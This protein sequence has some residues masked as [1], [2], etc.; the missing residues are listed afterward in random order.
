MT[1]QV[2][3]FVLQGGLDMVS[4][5]LTIE[6][7][8]LWRG[9]N[10]EPVE[11]G[12]RRIAG[13]ERYSGKPSPSDASYWLLSRTLTGEDATVGQ[14]VTGGTSAATGKLLTIAGDD[15][16]LGEVSGMFDTGEELTGPGGAIGTVSGT[17][18]KRGA[19]MLSDDEDYLDLAAA[20]RRAAIVKVPGSGPVRGV[21]SYAGD[22]FAVRDN[23][24]GMAGVMYRATS[25]GWTAV[26]GASLPVGGVY[27]FINHNFMGQ[28]G[29]LTMY[30]VN[31]V[32]KAFS[33]IKG[34]TTET[35]TWTFASI[36]T[37]GSGGAARDKPTHIAVQ[38]NHLLFAYR[39]G[40]LVYSSTG[41]PT[42]Y[43]AASGAGEIACGQEV[44]GLLGGVGLGN[45]LIVGSD[46][47][48][49]LYGN[50][51]EDFVLQDQSQANTG[52]VEGTL[53]AVGG[54][55]Y[56]D[57]RGVRSV[58]TTEAWGNWVIGTMTAD[59]QPW[60]DFQREARNI[61]A[62]SMRVRSNDQ[63]RLFFESGLGLAIYVGRDRPEMSFIDYGIDNDVTL[64][65]DEGETEPTVGDILTG[66]TSEATAR[67]GRVATTSGSWAG[68]NAAGTLSLY[69]VRGVFENDELV[70][71]MSGQ[72]ARVNG[73]A[74]S[75]SNR[76]IPRVSVSTE[77][78][79]RIERVYFGADNG[80]VY[81]AERGR[82]FDGREYD[83]Y[84]RMPLNH[85]KQPSRQKRFLSADIHLDSSGRVNLGL[86]ALYEDGINPEQPNTYADV[87]S[88]G[89]FWDEGIFDEFVY[90]APLNGY[91]T[92]D[93]AGIG[94]NVS[95]LLLAESAKQAPFTLNGISLHWSPRRMER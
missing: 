47:I 26:A 38:N 14:T 15:Y 52:G 93:L 27:R 12:Y 20:D 10:V 72:I 49:V 32:G 64:D 87:V 6:P 65:F 23:A 5:P 7:G 94:R 59:V 66:A 90:D 75:D 77:D 68:N 46:H 17:T 51:S 18:R 8:R 24:A 1:R 85:V 33:L 48:Q 41:D 19:T 3:H 61:A 42:T 43:E 63:Y 86:G 34:G 67:I 69:D 80:F 84:M 9:L 83:T 82:S 79:D 76:V 58:T 60:L 16:V 81:E 11:A 62:S 78:S 70:T 4:S 37:L 13:Y 30:G 36:T 55:I 39:G 91:H 71:T 73:T 53:Q 57:N 28:S 95:L 2:D 22:V 44:N 56:L 89:G 25:D 54:P 29:S 88:G 45:T 92:Y 35:P 50:D 31:G 21:W 40:S 74:V